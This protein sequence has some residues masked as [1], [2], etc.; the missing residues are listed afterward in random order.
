MEQITHTHATSNSTTGRLTSYLTYV[1]SSQA[2]VPR[3]WHMWRHITLYLTYVVPYYLVPDIYV[4]S[5]Q[6]DLP[7]TWPARGICAQQP[8]CLC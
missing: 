3:T 4:V 8:P 2:D 1:V 5:S 7:R 6:A